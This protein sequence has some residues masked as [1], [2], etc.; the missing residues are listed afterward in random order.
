[1]AEIRNRNSVQVNE[2][3]KQK[4]IEAK[5]V[6]HIYLNYKKSIWT[7]LDIAEAS[8]VSEKTVKRFFAGQSV[9]CDKAIAIAKAL[10]LELAESIIRNSRIPQPQRQKTQLAGTK[11]AKP[12]LTTKSAS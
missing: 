6:K 10:D 2:A 11:S 8:G 7:Y 12:A 3:G 9:D 1:M 5:A 4:L